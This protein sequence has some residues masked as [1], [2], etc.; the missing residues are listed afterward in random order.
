MTRLADA[1]MQSVIIKA[2]VPLPK[3]SPS[4]RDSHTM[5]LSIDAEWDA[6]SACAHFSRSS[7]LHT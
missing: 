3:E 2:P 7:L 6:R 5:V 1:E 4:T